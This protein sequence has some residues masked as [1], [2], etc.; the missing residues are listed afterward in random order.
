MPF[1]RKIR[2]MNSSS[3][4]WSNTIKKIIKLSRI[5]NAINAGA[6]SCRKILKNSNQKLRKIMIKLKRMKDKGLKFRLFCI[7]I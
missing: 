7:A 6:F 3:I 1:I 4:N 2:P 5:I